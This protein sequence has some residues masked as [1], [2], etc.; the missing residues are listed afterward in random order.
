MIVPILH[1][2]SRVSDTSELSNDSPQT[3]QTAESVAPQQTNLKESLKKKN[4]KDCAIALL[5]PDQQR[6]QARK[7][8][9]AKKKRRSI[10]HSSQGKPKAIPRSKGKALLK[11]YGL[12][13]VL[14]INQ[15]A[16]GFIGKLAMFFD[17]V[18]LKPVLVLNVKTE[19]INQIIDRHD[20]SK[21]VTYDS[22][23]QAAID[24]GVAIK[25][26]AA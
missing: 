1:T 7:R 25:E 13:N 18:T 6:E 15:M 24:C 14:I 8:R 5:T 2:S 3:L 26:V 10:T 12:K 16:I 20:P 17:S 9:E 19:I 22:A 23:R 11:R 4:K 21:P